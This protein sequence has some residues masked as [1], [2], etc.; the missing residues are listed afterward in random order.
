M[1]GPCGR[2][3]LYAI[4]MA[5]ATWSPPATAT[6]APLESYERIR[7]AADISVIVIY[8]VVVMAVGLWVCESS[9]K[10]AEGRGPLGGVKGAH[11][12]SMD[13]L[14]GGRWTCRSMDGR[15][16][17]RKRLRGVQ[18]QARTNR[19]ECTVY[20][21]GVSR[22]ACQEGR[23]RILEPVSRERRR[24]TAEQRKAQGTGQERGNLEPAGRS[25]GR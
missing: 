4:A 24:K 17:A 2:D 16:N 12:E 14:Q 25:S 1:S 7:N 3:G 13:E 18:G 22:G 15:G 5:S 21:R 19:R 8:F 11:G 9:G 10:W 20:G 23:R 6:A